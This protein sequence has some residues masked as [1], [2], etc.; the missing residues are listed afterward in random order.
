MKRR[1]FV[2]PPLLLLGGCRSA[3]REFR[4]A[5]RIAVAG[6]A[7]L[8]YLPVYLASAL[9][10][11]REAGID[12]EIQDLPSGPKAFQALLGGSTDLVAGAYEGGVQLSME[13]KPIEA[14][15]VLQRWPPLV[16]VVAPQSA[17]SV[18]TIADLKGR[19][20]GVSSPGSTTHRFLNYLLARNGFAPSDV[21]P[22]G[23]GVNFSM[24]AAVQHGKVAA[25][26]AGPLGVA[27]LSKQS[28]PMLLADCRTEQGAKST[29]GTND[30][31]SSSLM[32]RVEWTRS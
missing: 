25:A 28:P 17:S 7:A 29:L 15:A 23:V 3:R 11:F 1:S 4:P 5:V 12:A 6:R 18:R 20:V 30:L 26:V 13:G 10:F 9:G 19:M 27:L 22:V 31:P 2:L 32:V 14:V 16:L 21:T 8:D 24:A